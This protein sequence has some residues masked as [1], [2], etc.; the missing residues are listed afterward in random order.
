MFW[1]KMTNNNRAD[2]LHQL[3]NAKLAAGHKLCKCVTLWRSVMS[4][5]HG[6]KYQTTNEVFQEQWGR[7]EFLLIPTLTF[8]TFKIL[9]MQKKV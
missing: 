6:I 4:Q 3:S 8:L 2:V 5:S 9:Y 7:E 1:P